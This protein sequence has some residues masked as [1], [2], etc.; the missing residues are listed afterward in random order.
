MWEHYCEIEHATIGVGKGEECN[1][2]GRDEEYYKS[3]NTINV[4]EVIENEDGSCDLKMTISDESTRQLIAEGFRQLAEEMEAKIVVLPVNEGQF[5]KDVKQYELS[6]GE[7][8]LLLQ[9]GFTRALQAGF[10]K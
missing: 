3:E 2:C 5:S 7:A 9:L 10:E 4:D 6:D 1:W 8:Q